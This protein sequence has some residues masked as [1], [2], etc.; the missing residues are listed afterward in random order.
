[1]ERCPTHRP[2]AIAT[3][4]HHAAWVIASRRHAELEPR[5]RRYRSPQ[6]LS[7]RVWRWPRVKTSGLWAFSSGSGSLKKWPSPEIERWLAADL[8]KDK[9]LK[10]A[11]P[12][13]HA[14]PG[15]GN[16]TVINNDRLSKSQSS[17]RDRSE[18]A[19]ALARGEYASARSARAT[20]WGSRLIS[21]GAKGEFVLV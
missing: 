6:A 21:S 5:P 15:R 9:E 18:I 11:K 1:M 13:V 4:L 8:A 14:P 20:V 16:K 3:R 19:E 10:P 17:A 2:T 12:A 7:W